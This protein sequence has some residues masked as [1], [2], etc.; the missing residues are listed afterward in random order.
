MSLFMPSRPPV[1]SVPP[2]PP[3][4]ADKLRANPPF[5]KFAFAN[6]YNLSL[7]GG[8]LTIAGLTL[9]PIIGVAALGA[10]ALWLLHAPGS[11]LLTRKLWKPKLDQMCDQIERA[12][13]D[14]RIASLDPR[15]QRRVG[16]LVDQQ[17]RIDNLASQNP[18]FAGDLLRDELAKSGLLVRSF[19]DMAL[20]CNRYEGYLSS[21]DLKE[22]ERDRQQ[23]ETRL[24]NIAP[25]SPQ[26]GV[27]QKNLDVIGKRQTKIG[28]IRE[29]LV[30]AR[31]Q[32][33]LIENT[34]NLI[35]DQIVTMQSPRELSGQLD[36]LMSGV[37]SV[38][39]AAA[40]TE[41]LLI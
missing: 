5:L 3:V 8:A 40:Y 24:K 1:P 20:N 22:L 14:S 16:A 15:D 19:I 31:G 38:Q 7:V 21:V 34:F 32:L 17:R 29:Y 2:N 18:S 11:D 35:A 23:W 10:E 33:D 41:T 12:Q 27:A 13:L 25:D 4:S 36:D 30:L 28:E 39:Q 26:A 6:P 37:E 9:N